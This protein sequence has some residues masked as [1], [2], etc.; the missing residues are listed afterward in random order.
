MPVKRP[1][2]A[3]A[4]A[5]RLYVAETIRDWEQHHYKLQSQLPLR[6]CSV[7]TVPPTKKQKR[8][9]LGEI[10]GNSTSMEAQKRWKTTFRYIG[11][12]VATFNNSSCFAKHCNTTNIL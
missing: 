12:R 6:Y 11:C 8:V 3:L 9:V 2:A 5:K 7:C 4:P 10:S 1:Q